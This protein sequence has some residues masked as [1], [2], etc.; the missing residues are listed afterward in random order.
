M[1]GA[2]RALRRPRIVS[3]GGP[4]TSREFYLNFLGENI[5]NTSNDFWLVSIRYLITHL[6]R[7]HIYS[8]PPFLRAQ[9]ILLV[10]Q[11]SGN[12]R[13]ETGLINTSKIEGE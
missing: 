7:V 9:S 2:I 6:P 4:A 12:A 8:F 3:R 1:P 5:S 10:G 13:L 11:R